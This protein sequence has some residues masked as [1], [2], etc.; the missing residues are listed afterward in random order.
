MA[1]NIS[2]ETVTDDVMNAVLHY[3]L[4][5]IAENI[6]YFS[7]WQILLNFG[8]DGSFIVTVEEE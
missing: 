4:S 6:E 5:N 2:V 8:E 3:G 7:D 1:N